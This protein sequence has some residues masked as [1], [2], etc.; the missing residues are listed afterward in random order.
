MISEIIVG[1][2]LMVFGSMGTGLVWIVKTILQLQ[3]DNNAAH[4][5]NRANEKRIEIL[6]SKI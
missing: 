2:A 3:K 1:L 5:K 6:E 4:F